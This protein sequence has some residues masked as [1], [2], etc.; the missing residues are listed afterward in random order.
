MYCTA[1]D[2]R[3]IIHTSLG[4]SEIDGIIEL[5][6]AEIDK[7]L[8]TQDASDK[9]IKK[10]SMLLTAYTIKVRQP[11]RAQLVRLKLYACAPLTSCARSFEHV[12]CWLR[13]IFCILFDI[14]L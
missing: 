3:S 8:G 10:L 11:A 4:D 6:D 13:A 14:I 2:V 5:S 7:K 12:L 1:A 9:L